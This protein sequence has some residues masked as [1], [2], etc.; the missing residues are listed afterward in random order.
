MFR[1]TLFKKLNFLSLKYTLLNL[2]CNCYF[3]KFYNRRPNGLKGALQEV[4]IIFEGREHSGC[5]KK[6]YFM[7]FIFESLFLVIGLHDSRNTAMLV[8]KMIV[9]GCR[10]QVTKS[11]QSV[12]IHS[13][14]IK[15]AL[16]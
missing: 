3:K 9:D 10:L 11:I 12:S 7:G 4:G 16:A 1:I 8:K 14:S 5:Y 2:L 13:F 15:A 6:V